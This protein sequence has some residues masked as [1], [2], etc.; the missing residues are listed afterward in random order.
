METFKA[1][2]QTPLL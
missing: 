2:E 1:E